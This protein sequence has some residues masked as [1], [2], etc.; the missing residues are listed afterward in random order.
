MS[1]IHNKRQHCEN[2]YWGMSPE[3]MVVP[4]LSETDVFFVFRPLSASKHLE[5]EVK[6]T[7]TKFYSDID[8]TENESQWVKDNLI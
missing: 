5:I 1:N 2:H 3:F 8:L 4:H 7:E 6:I